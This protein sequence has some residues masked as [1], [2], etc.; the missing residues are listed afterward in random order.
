MVLCTSF[1]VFAEVLNRLLGLHAVVVAV[2]DVVQV[3]FV[4]HRMTRNFFS[5]IYFDDISRISVT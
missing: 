2:V 5:F 3:I 1:R 4:K